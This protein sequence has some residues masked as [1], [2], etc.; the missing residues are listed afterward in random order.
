ME[1]RHRL[2]CG[3]TKKDAAD[4]DENVRR[5]ASNK[6]Y[7]K[8]SKNP[9]ANQH[10]CSSYRNLGLKRGEDMCGWQHE[11]CSAGTKPIGTCG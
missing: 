10:D 8:S 2:T 4:S 6:V 5:L 3:S 11:E 9:I 7:G 1:L